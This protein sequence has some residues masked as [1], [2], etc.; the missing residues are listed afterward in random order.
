MANRYLFVGE[1]PSPTATRKGWTWES[2]RL[3]A[4][5]L[6]D[7][8]RVCEINPQT[9]GFVNL[10]GDHFNSPSIVNAN[11]RTPVIRAAARAGITVVAFGNKVSRA[12]HDRDVPHIAMRH[13][14][15]RGSG[16][17]K[18]IYTAHVLR[19]LQGTP[20]HRSAA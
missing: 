10:F 2:G 12:L 19:A 11:Y 13:P 6:F 5:T 7:A 8:L 20:T 14:A 15:A 4:K 1:K 3:A 17:A 9:C 18:D 16:R